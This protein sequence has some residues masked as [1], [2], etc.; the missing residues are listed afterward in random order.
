MLT[1]GLT[2]ILRLGLLAYPRGFRRRRGEEL[3]AVVVERLAAERRERGRKIG[4]ASC[5]ERV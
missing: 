3:G 4:R 1:R 5:R 2:A